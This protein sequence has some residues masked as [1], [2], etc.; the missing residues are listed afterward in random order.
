MIL[1]KLRNTHGGAVI[2]WQDFVEFEAKPYNYIFKKDV[3][4]RFIACL[5][6][7]L[8]VIDRLKLDLKIN[9]FNNEVCFRHERS[10]KAVKTTLEGR[11]PDEN[12]FVEKG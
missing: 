11:V 3:Q 4:K 8:A 5:D 7:L 6:A 1:F 10:L 12:L 9:E 2:S